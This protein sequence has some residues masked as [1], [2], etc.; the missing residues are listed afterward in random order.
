MAPTY[1][2]SFPTIKVY[3]KV[4]T[5][6]QRV[7]YKTRT[8]GAKGSSGTKE[9]NI[10]THPPTTFVE[11]K[12]VCTNGRSKR[13]AGASRKGT[14]HPSRYQTPEA[15]RYSSPN[16]R[17]ED[18]KS[19]KKENWPFPNVESCRR[20]KEVLRQSE[21]TNIFPYRDTEGQDAPTNQTSHS[22]V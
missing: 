20:P 4:P 15:L 9:N 13:L 3:P 14:N 7:N 16:G 8:K 17:C 19:G 22:R 6:T 12:N 11:K 1:P 21:W 5:P 18:K 10:Y 2:V